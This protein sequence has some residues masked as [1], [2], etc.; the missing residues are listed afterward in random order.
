VIV[1]LALSHGGYGPGAWGWGAVLGL[2]AAILVLS[3]RPRI[4]LVPTQIVWFALASSLL[5]WTALSATWSLSVPRTML[6]VERDLLYVAAIAALILIAR[7]R[8]ATS[9]ATGVAW[10]IATVGVW[11]LVRY[12]I[13]PP[14]VDETQ[15]YQLFQPIGYSN[16]LGG[17]VAI[18]L[19]LILAV[20]ATDGRRAVRSG[21]AAAAVV[22]IVALYLTQNRSGWLAL[23]LA[24]AVWLFA[25]SDRSRAVAALAVAG[26]PATVAV[27]A[28]SRLDLLDRTASAGTRREPLLLGSVTVA[29]LALG[30]A[31]CARVER[32]ERFDARAG[33]RAAQL[34]LLATAAGLAFAGSHLGLRSHYW[35]VAAKGAERYWPLGSGAGT[36]D[37]QWFRYR[38]VAVGVRD[39]HNLYLETLTELGVIG[40]LVVVGVLLI[41]LVVSRRVHEPMLAA[42]LA[43]YCAFL[44][45][46]AFEWD[47]EMP[48]VTFAALV[49]AATLV[50]ARPGERAMQ[51]GRGVRLG[52]T[53]VLGLLTVFAVVTLAGNEYV[54]AAERRAVAGD[55]A[56]AEKRARRADRLIP[57]A[58]EPWLVIGDSRARAGNYV[59]AR[60][61]LRKAISRDP[62]DWTL[63]YR[64]TAISAGDARNT[65]LRQALT[66]NPLLLKRG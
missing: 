57:W 8:D 28:V 34:S 21:S 44:L 42:A 45:H 64:L 12:V 3:L 15:G 59:R 50:L 32:W 24:L 37:E 30:A 39:V 47:W 48:V 18:G 40:L 36:F 23:S 52:A 51:F 2:W 16:A 1:V 31:A 29:A 60:S 53:A 58:S 9:I 38:D 20:L 14:P 56:G 7:Q 19:P 4:S 22:L 17:L 46:A 49:L 26:I 43:G 33:L 61:A 11:S 54:V 27:T 65:A 63:W 35:N 5:A 55:S 10:G 6:E 66:L 41:P 62:S 25:T 13:A